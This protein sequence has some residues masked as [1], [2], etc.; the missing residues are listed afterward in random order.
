MAVV[1]LRASRCLQEH[2]T[3]WPAVTSAI[4]GRVPWKAVDDAAYNPP[5]I[6][7]K[8]AKAGSQCLPWAYMESD[9]PYLSQRQTFIS[10]GCDANPVSHASAC[11]AA[12]AMS[13][14]FPLFL[15]FLESSASAVDLAEAL[16]PWLHAQSET[17]AKSRSVIV[18][19]GG[20][21]AS[22][23]C[24][25]A[26]AMASCAVRRNVGI[27]DV[28]DAAHAAE[29]VAQ[30]ANAI[31]ES[32]KRRMP[33]RFKVAGVECKS[34]P[35]SDKLRVAWVSQLMQVAGVSEEIAKVVASR[36]PSP[37]SL[38]DAVAKADPRGACAAPT[39]AAASMAA[40]E[41]F[42]ADLEYPIRGK[43][44]TRRMGPILSRRIFML[45]HPCVSASMDL[46]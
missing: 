46:A 27:V 30:C 18:C 13:T 36:Y 20:R 10:S 15:A 3:L 42:L 44:S 24:K 19:F 21:S 41:S 16:Q 23:S 5:D 9:F 32:K 37:A 4:E 29:Y 14:R 25:V 33:S 34:L 6:P 45:F 26:I 8:R 35:R 22:K 7:G 11:E 43:K 12:E 2:K 28:H 1:V 31:T 38:L 17:L 39:A 40:A